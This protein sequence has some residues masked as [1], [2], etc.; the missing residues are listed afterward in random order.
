MS[1]LLLG[2]SCHVP[3]LGVSMFLCVRLCLCT[4][5]ELPRFYRAQ[6]KGPGIGMRST[7]A[8]VLFVLWGQRVVVCPLHVRTTERWDQR[9]N[10]LTGCLCRR[11]LLGAQPGGLRIEPERRSISLD[12]GIEFFYDKCLIANAGKN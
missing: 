12:D 11:R 5:V 2:W 3:C 6:S 9:G 1:F 8:A 7:F 10:F 4:G